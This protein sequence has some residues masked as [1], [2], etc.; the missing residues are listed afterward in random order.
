MMAIR[1]SGRSSIIVVLMINVSNPVVFPFKKIVNLFN[2]KN[3]GTAGT[4]VVILTENFKRFG[5]SPISG[6]YWLCDLL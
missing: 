4:I 2:Q 5:S 1:N 6:I 3:L